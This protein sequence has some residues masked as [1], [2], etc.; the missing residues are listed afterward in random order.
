MKTEARDMALKILMEVNVEGAYSNIAINRNLKGDRGKLDESLVREIVYGVLENRLY[1]DY[2]IGKLSKI[3][4]NKMEPVILEI[5]RIGVYQI[6]FL[7]KIPNSA[8]VNESVKLAKK[9][10]NPGSV[11]FVNGMLRNI[12]RK[13]ES[14]FNID[15][16]NEIDYLSIKYSHPKWLVERCIREF[17]DDFTKRLC[18]ANNNRPKLNIRTNSFKISRD[19]LKARLEANGILVSETQY[20]SDGLILEQPFRIINTEEYKDGLFTIQDESSM[21]VA[22]IMNPKEGSFVI[23]LCSAPG[24]KTTHISEK[25]K[26]NGR[27]L[28]RDIYD[29]KIKLVEENS[30]RLGS[31]IIETEV[32]DA[33]ILDEK[34][35]ESADYVL[36]D[37]PCTGLGMIRRR[38]EI[39]WNR[40]ESDIENISIIQSKILENGSKYLKPGGV[41]IYSTCTIGKDENLNVIL[42]FLKRNDNYNFC[43]FDKLLNSDEGM[44]TAKD[45]YIELYPHIHNMDG[46]FIAKLMKKNR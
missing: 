13:K 14:I 29:H 35:I 24:G 39:K 19:D 30:Q 1:L 37:A 33:S 12:C 7:G 6:R 34:L 16:K 27:I 9:Y 36:I 25:M 38:P 10:S 22:Q 46:F 15:K 42:D 44:K 8:A 45:G 28:A 26:N 11:K 40:I 20:S 31:S 43:S 3:K 17:G 18:I 21:L 41:L 4:L 5:L 2:V 23:D 32:F